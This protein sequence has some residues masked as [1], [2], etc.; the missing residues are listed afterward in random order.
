MP[1]K[2]RRTPDRNLGYVL[3]LAKDL[4]LPGVA[5]RAQKGVFLKSPSG[6]IHFGLRGA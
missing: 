6:P 4:A 1:V 3:P 5:A 2:F